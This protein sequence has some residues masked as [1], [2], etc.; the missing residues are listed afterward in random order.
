MTH[1]FEFPPN[2]V[3]AFTL[4]DCAWLATAIHELTGF[5][6]VTASIDMPDEWVHCAVRT[7]EGLVLDIEGTWK[8][9]DWLDHWLDGEPG[10]EHMLAEWTLP[11]FTAARFD[12]ERQFYGWIPAAEWAPKV[13]AAYREMV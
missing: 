11:G 6:I 2:A 9:N 12:A 13:L 7:P 8:V 4:G 3:R 5:T 1:R 10:E